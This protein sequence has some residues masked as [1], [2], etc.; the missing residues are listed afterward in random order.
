[1]AEKEKVGTACWPR[2]KRR[3]YAQAEGFENPQRADYRRLLNFLSKNS[4]FCQKALLSSSKIPEFA[5]VKTI[6]NLRPRTV[7]SVETPQSTEIDAMANELLESHTDHVDDVLP[8]IESSDLP[9]SNSK[10]TDDKTQEILTPVNRP[11]DDVSDLLEEPSVSDLFQEKPIPKMTR[12]RF[13]RQRINRTLS[14]LLIEHAFKESPKEEYNENLEVQEV[15]VETKHNPIEEINAL[16]LPDEVIQEVIYEKEQ[17]F[18]EKKQAPVSKAQEMLENWFSAL[19]NDDSYD[20]YNDDDDIVEEEE[21]NE[22]DVSELIDNPK[23]LLEQ[24]EHIANGESPNTATKESQL[25]H[26]RKRSS[27]YRQ[28]VRVKPCLVPLANG[29]RK[30]IYP[31][32]AFVV[33]DSLGKVVAVR[34]QDNIT[35]R[36]KR[37]NEGSLTAFTRFR[38][39]GSI[40]SSG[41]KDKDGVIVRDPCGRVRAQG[42]S[43][44]CDP[45]GCLTIRKFDGQFWSLDL[46]KGIHIE[47]RIL[48]DLHG[49]WSS[50]TALLSF[51]GFRMATKFQELTDSYRRYGDWLSSTNCSKFRFYGRDGSMVQFNSDEELQSLRPSFTSPPGSKRVDEELTGRRQART[52]WDSVHEYISQFLATL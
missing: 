12:G 27:K 50:L 24:L 32:G 1:M 33:K 44:S 14:Q 19:D 34:S 52:A 41:E 23:K 17:E 46:V 7:Q 43:M 42:E 11:W 20:V 8:V 26:A 45:R 36:F 22:T 39:D 30:E 49:H 40:H 5:A 3:A 48:E 51:D 16:N 21:E 31:N 4:E 6:L 15:S 28:N 35:L 2:H 13:G 37:D 47:R 18:E 10:D 38:A 25:K 29:A 9:L